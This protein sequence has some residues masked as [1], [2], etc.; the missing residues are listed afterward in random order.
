ME[1][2]GH[3]R[4]CPLREWGPLGEKRLGSDGRELAE[5]HLLVEVSPAVGEWIAVS[6]QAPPGW[7]RLWGPTRLEGR[8]AL[9]AEAAP[10]IDAR[11]LCDRLRAAGRSLP[12]YVA[13]DIARAVAAAYFEQRG[14]LYLT[15]DRLRLTWS[16]EVRLSLDLLA[17]GGWGEF[18][19]NWRPEQLATLP[20]EIIR[21][22]PGDAR[23]AVYSA[24]V[25]LLMLLSKGAPYRA[26]SFVG[27]LERVV[28]GRRDTPEE[29]WEQ[30]P[31]GLGA[32][33]ERALA[34]ELDRRFDHPLQLRERLKPFAG[35]EGETQ[36][37]LARNLPRLAPWDFSRHQLALDLLHGRDPEPLPPGLEARLL[38]GPDDDDA[39]AVLADHLLAAGQ[40]RGELAEVQRRLERAT[41]IER[42]VLLRHER[43]LFDSDARL[44]PPQPLRCTYRRGYVRLLEVG[45]DA[46]AGAL[47]EAMV[48]PSLR[49][50]HTLRVTRLRL[51]EPAL[52]ALAAAKHRAV[53][54]LELPV[55][56]L[57]DEPALRAAL[58]RLE[59]I[60][61]HG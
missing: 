25:L 51:A 56:L 35:R 55:G 17:G 50:L 46:D 54:R 26:E 33:L 4:L 39:W 19:R 52:A 30:L 53:R 22:L 6:R 38:D 9:A 12:T 48:H 14:A 42:E 23:T 10:G 41:G 49:F 21:G 44:E 15:P 40:P 43:V 32:V 24:A 57:V 5:F 13:V 34:V 37:W 59:A 2:P 16:G 27:L 45:P 29:L 3:W 7:L 36:T 11:K 61:S 47:E 28:E 58:P 20:P 8:E 1:R 31:S 18:P 60:V